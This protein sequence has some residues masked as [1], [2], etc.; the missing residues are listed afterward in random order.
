LSTF[1]PFK[2]GTTIYL[3]LVAIF[4]LFFFL[5][6][7]SFPA[8]LSYTE[9]VLYLLML[10]S[11]YLL[12][13]FMIF[14]PPK[15]NSLSMDSS[16]FLT[17]IF[18]FGVEISLSLLLCSSILFFIFK[19]ETLLWKHIFNFSIFVLMIVS[20]YY[21]FVGTGGVV[22]EINLIG[23]HSYLLSLLVYL[24]LNVSFIAI[25][26]WFSSSD[27]S[28]TIIKGILKESISNYFII[29][30]SSLI[31][32]ILLKTYPIFGIIIFTLVVVLISKALKEYHFLYEEVSMDRNYREQILN[33]LPVGIITFDDRRKTYTL[34]TS[35]ERLLDITKEEVGEFVSSRNK[36]AP[37]RAF[38]DILSSK[39]ITHNVKTPYQTARANYTLLVSQAELIDQYENS[40]GR[41][42]SFIDIT[43]IEDL[44]KRIYQ[45][46]KLALLGEISAK[47]AHEIRNP[48]TVIYGF[49]TIMKQS[50]SKSEQ[51]QHQLP[52]M[53][54][55]FER[56]NSIIDEML[57]IAKPNPPWLA[58][59]YIGDII[60][61]VLTLYTGTTQELQFN[62][63]ID[64]VPLLLD[65]RQIT[66]VLYNLIRNSV[67]AIGEKGTV[68]IYSK[69]QDDTY[70]LFIK[71]TGTGIPIEIRKT[72]FEPF[73]TSKDSGTGLGLTIVQRII[74]NHKG[75]IELYS[76]SEEGTTFLI[77]L[78][79]KSLN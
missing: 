61:E 52:L 56:I 20:S 10:I 13:H 4:G 41:I 30:L 53:L 12:Y 25:Y 74:E 55:E 1:A 71:D 19:R 38:W 75:K 2:K 69:I 67:E 5:L 15:G 36:T 70:E 72:I 50:F 28:F 29:L 8:N 43:E 66:Q 79:L 9:W 60:E 45:S 62:L 76:S 35:A 34:N 73:L 3:I 54:K 27:R 63:N 78:P 11:I 18:I 77:T 22:G 47:A 16:I 40:I 65:K 64:R 6:H 48:L 17:S 44:E 23:I 37:N 59:T 51:E 49:L 7:F 46:E 14:L 57:S 33:S 21:I 58:E 31:L 68:S 32:T 24:F 26:F 39:K 42:F